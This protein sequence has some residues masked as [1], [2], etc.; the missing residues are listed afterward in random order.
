MNTFNTAAANAMTVMSIAQKNIVDTIVN[1]S[2]SLR[3]G[4]AK[5]YVTTFTANG[6]AEFLGIEL[7]TTKLPIN[8]G[9]FIADYKPK[10]VGTAKVNGQRFPMYDTSDVTFY[11][12]YTTYCGSDLDMVTFHD[13][14]WDVINRDDAGHYDMALTDSGV[15]TYAPNITGLGK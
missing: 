8:V 15:W 7:H 5:L 13:S 11:R 9:G 10:S 2:P 3:L 14:E 1:Y 6:G 12:R 4:S